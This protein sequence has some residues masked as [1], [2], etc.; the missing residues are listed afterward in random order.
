MSPTKPQHISGEFVI[1]D[2]DNVANASRFKFEPGSEPALEH[3]EALMDRFQEHEKALG[4][5]H[6]GQEAVLR[7]HLFVPSSLRLLSL[8]LTSPSPETISFRPIS[9]RAF[10]SSHLQQY[11]TPPAMWPGGLHILPSR[12][13]CPSTNFFAS[14]E[15][16]PMKRSFDKVDEIP[17]YEGVRPKALVFDA[18]AILE[19]RT[20]ICHAMHKVFQKVFP[21]HPMP[22]QDEIMEA[23]SYSGAWPDMLAH[24][25]IPKKEYRAKQKASEEAYMK[26][27]GKANAVEQL[28]YFSDSVRVL[29]A[30]KEEGFVLVLY[31]DNSPL[32]VDALLRLGT[33]DIFDIYIDNEN[34]WISRGVT[35]PPRPI[36][37]KDIIEAYDEYLKDKGLKVEGKPFRFPFSP[38]QRPT[39]FPHTGDDSNKLKREEMMLI[40]GTIKQ[41]ESHREKGEN[42]ETWNY[43]LVYVARTEAEISVEQESWCAL[44]VEDLDEFGYAVFGLALP[45]TAPARPVAP[46]RATDKVVD[47]VEKEVVEVEDGE[48]DAGEQQSKDAADE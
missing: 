25:G 5:V 1:T 43:P 46:G 42:S 7:V 30:A 31:S 12:A 38:L 40:E 35:A 8:Q 26:A 34:A 19:N 45:E 11:P 6:E 23:Y 18:S 32:I 47:L 28:A 41:L 17:K 13:S 27:Y 33:V 4:R 36:E 29:R 21:T 16:A 9:L 48:K 44:M 10:L 39:E 37:T 15:R 2:D 3:L 22:T 20:G 14:R 24:L